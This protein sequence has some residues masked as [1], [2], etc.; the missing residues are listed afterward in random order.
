MAG[1]DEGGERLA[2]G[3]LWSPY[4]LEPSA[5]DSVIHRKRLKIGG[6]VMADTTMAKLGV[7]IGT[8]RTTGTIHSD[9]PSESAKL[10]ATDVYEW[11]PGEAFIL[12]HVDGLMGDAPV[13]A[14]EIVRC[15]ETR[16]LLSQSIDNGGQFSE[17]SLDLNGRHWRINGPKE[18]FEG[19]FNEDFTILEGNWFTVVDGEADKPWMR[20]MLEKQS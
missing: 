4:P 2:W 5:S 1:S 6:S 10:V 16:G 20:I 9:A 13:K 15:D 8:W 7:F 3:A 17:Y 19:E 12:H 14:L 11:F 18:R